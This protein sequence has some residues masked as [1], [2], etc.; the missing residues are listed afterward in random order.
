VTRSDGQRTAK[1][2]GF[3]QWISRR[4]F[5]IGAAAS[6]F[7]FS[8]W[9]ACGGETKEKAAMDQTRSFNVLDFGAKADGKADD[10]AAIQKAIDAASE[11][12][13]TVVLADGVYLCSAI[14]L[15]PQTGLVGNPTWSYQRPG[16]AI[17]RLNDEKAACLLDMTGAVGSTVNGICLDGQGLGEGVHGILVDKPEYKV[18]DSFRIDRCQIGRFSGDGVR[19][20]RIWCWSMRHNMLCY[21]KENGLRIRGWDGFLLDNWFSGNGAAGFGAYD[22]NSSITMTG[23]RIEWNRAG[24]IVIHSGNHYNITGN[25]IDRSGAPGISLLGIDGRCSHFAITGNVIYRSGA[26][27]RELDRKDSSHARFEN[28]EG[29]V[30][31]GNVMTVGRDDGG[32]GEYSPRCGIVYGKI[33]NSVIKDNAMQ[34]GALEELLVDLGGHGDGAVV[35]DN[36][37]VVGKPNW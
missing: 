11:K 33:E 13:G 4:Q 10:T 34:R 35:K 36:V 28:V 21:N 24:G 12:L 29:L 25:Y 26:P 1:E 3:P 30:F 14:K 31:S 5:V 8:E 27:W 19:L 7:I 20:N 9:P 37:G 18:E 2:I 32:R 23:N 6:V 22:E 16:G 15:R 17:L